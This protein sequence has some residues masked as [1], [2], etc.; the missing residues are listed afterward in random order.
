[1]PTG[2]VTPVVTV[3][4]PSNHRQR[5]DSHSKSSASKIACAGFQPRLGYVL[6][7]VLLFF[8]ACG[9]GRRRSMIGSTMLVPR[10]RRPEGRQGPRSRSCAD[11]DRIGARR[12][13]KRRERPRPRGARPA[14]YRRPAS[15]LG[16]PRCRSHRRLAI[17]N[18]LAGYRTAQ[19]SDSP[20][21][22][23]YATPRRRP[24]HVPWR[25]GGSGFASFTT[26]SPSP[27]IPPVCPEMQRWPTSD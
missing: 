19:P 15:R 20:R 27:A 17:T 3:T 4:T 14:E 5:P 26:C 11:R 25:P 16:R 22:S 23:R 13:T 12:N 10:A 24:Y 18:T 2:V 6:L 8:P 21:A 9:A 1:M 7:L